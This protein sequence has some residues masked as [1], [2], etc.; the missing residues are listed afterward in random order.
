[1]QASLQIVEI[2]LFEELLGDLAA[3]LGVDHWSA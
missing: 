3:G 2:Q 1:M